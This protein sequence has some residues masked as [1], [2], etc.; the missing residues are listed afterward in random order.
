MD[1]M[2]NFMDL[3]FTVEMYDKCMEGVSWVTSA[4]FL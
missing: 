1:F 4:L 2:S 3:N